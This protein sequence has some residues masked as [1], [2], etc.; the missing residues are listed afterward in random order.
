MRL[1]KELQTLG[2]SLMAWGICFALSVILLFAFGVGTIRIGPRDVPMLFPTIHSLSAV[3]LMKVQADILPSYVKLVVTDPVDAMMAQIGISFFLAFSLCLPILLWQLFSYISPGLYTRE[4]GILFRVMLFSSPLFLS[5]VFFGYLVI[6]PSFIN[7][8]YLYA[9]AMGAETFITVRNL[10]SF[11]VPVLALSGVLF[12]VPM[13]MLALTV[14]KIIPQAAWKT[15]W[16][17]VVVGASI[18]SA[19]ITPDGTGI[20]MIFMFLS[21]VVLYLFGLFLIYAWRKK[22]QRT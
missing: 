1:W 6:L 4:R 12:L 13:I 19:I 15:K 11:V 7:I 22:L 5:G 17:Q 21:I 20:T 9:T 14:V 2:H 8:L 18:F 3:L 16:R 10:V